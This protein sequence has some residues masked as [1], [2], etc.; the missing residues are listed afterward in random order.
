[1][2]T[3]ESLSSEAHDHWDDARALFPVGREL[4]DRNRLPAAR[5]VLE[6]CIE[7]D[8]SGEPDAYAYLSYAWYRDSNAPKGDE[9][10]RRG[11]EATGS[12]DLRSTLSNFTSDPEEGKALRESIAGSEV[13]TI[14]A[15]LLAQEFYSSK[16]PA[17]A[18]EAVMAHAAEH[19]DVMDIQENLMWTLISA[20]GRKLV[21]GLDLHEVAV[22]LADRK[23]AADPD[24]VFGYWMKSQMMIQ[25]EDWSGLLATTEAAL[26][27][28][29]DDETMMQFRGRACRKSGDEA[30]AMDWFSRAI[31]AKHSFAGA[32]VELAKIHEDNGRLDVAEAIFREIPGANPDYTAGPVSVALFLAR[33]ERWAEAEE[34]FLA[35]WPNLPAWYRGQFMQNPDA[36]ALL[37]RKAVQSVVSPE[38][39]E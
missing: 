30:R 14:Q 3:I 25:E 37:D 11:I 15:A 13:P 35:A 18:L 8:P 34:T 2:R 23:I 1:M 31:G 38:T 12:D 24:E 33:Q 27:R 6:R 22:P 36:K 9:T 28:F 10:L 17:T 39:E 16:E 19:A 26:A 20:K 21:E 7:L 29:P 32:R 5:T 4:H